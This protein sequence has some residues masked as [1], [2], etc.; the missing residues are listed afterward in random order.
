[1]KKDRKTTGEKRN[2]ARRQSIRIFFSEEEMEKIFKGW[3]PDYG[4]RAAYI[5]EKLLSRKVNYFYMNASWDQLL[6]E[7]VAI[8]REW[9]TALEAIREWRNSWMGA[10]EPRE[11]PGEWLRH[12]L[13]PVIENQRRME[14][15]IHKMGR[16]W[17][18]QYGSLPAQERP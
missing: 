14:E 11:D 10:Q 5:R 9:R 15:I 2:P 16:E 13:E 4:S 8:K 12:R 1:M 6:E 7:M 3:S 17:L 18:R